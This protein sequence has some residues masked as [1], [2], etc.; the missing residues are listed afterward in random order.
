MSMTG[1][2][3][4]RDIQIRDPFV[5]PVP[6]ESRYYL[7]GTTDRNP[8]NAPG[9]GFDA[10]VAADLDE[11][12]GPIPV[13]RRDERFWGTHDFWAPEVHR[14]RGR[15]YMFAT[16]I[17]EGRKRGTQILSSDVPLGPFVPVTDG[18]ATPPEWHCLDG[19][20]HVDR[21]GT[22]WIVFCHEW[23]EV[24][25]GEIWAL[26]LSDDLRSPSGDR[27]LLFCASEAA[28]TKPLPRRD[29]SGLVDARVTDGPFLYRAGDG[30]LFLLWSS[31]GEDGYVM[32]Y[33]RSASGEL[34]GPWLQS[35]RPLI[36]GD[37]GHG[38]LFR[39]LHGGL[40]GAY[41]APNNTPRERFRYVEIAV[42]ADRLELAKVSH[43][44]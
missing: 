2:K 38:M 43:G 20:L 1:K 27:R 35:K 15:Y 10:Y 4:R 36:S 33:A 8:W 23:V 30:S 14:Y 19:T 28:W 40:Y 44:H 7:Y 6:E 3:N 34:A 25:D 26:P 16:F 39:G 31:I 22:P 21:E 17:A 9:E 5:L 18:P 11:W 41:H 37:G 29:G 24:H 32:G 13:F 12:E 42:A